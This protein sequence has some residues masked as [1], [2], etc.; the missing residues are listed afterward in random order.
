[1][2]EKNNGFRVNIEDIP[3][4]FKQV[5]EPSYYL[6]VTGT[7]VPRHLGK[8][9]LSP[10]FK[11]ISL[12]Y[13]SSGK[14]LEL[15]VS[16]R[17]DTFV[18]AD[19]ESYYYYL[20]LPID[21]LKKTFH[22][23]SVREN[24]CSIYCD[25]ISFN[26]DF[27]IIK[28][29]DKIL[30]T[31]GRQD[32][33]SAPPIPL[34]SE[35]DLKNKLE[36]LA[37]I[38]KTVV[39]GVYTQSQKNNKTGPE[40]DTIFYIRGRISTKED[41]DDYPDVQTDVQKHEA[42][43]RTAIHKI[44]PD[45]IE[46][47]IDDV[48]GVDE[49]KEEIMEMVDIF[50]NPQKY[51]KLGA[52]V[53]KGALLTGPPGAGKTMLALAVAKVV[54]LPI[55]CADGS[56]FVQ[57][58]VGR[59]A[60]RIRE[61]FAE[62]RKN[63]PCV[64][65]IDELDSLAKQRTGGSGGSSEYEHTLGQLL[66][67]LDGFKGKKNKGIIVIGATNVPEL[68]DPGVT[69]PGRLDRQ[70]VLDLPDAEGR[71]AI[72]RVHFRNKPIAENVDLKKIALTTPGFSGA[73]IALMANEAA[74]LAARGEWEE[75]YKTHI[76]LARE[77]VKAGVPRKTRLTDREKIG[78]AHHEAGHAI[79]QTL[80]Y[81]DADPVEFAT[82]IP[83]GN[84]LG[85]VVPF[86]EEDLR[87]LYKNRLEAQLVIF[88]AGRVAEEIHFGKDNYS[89]AAQ[90]DISKAT[91]FVINMIARW[92]MG[93]IGFINL[94]KDARFRYL[95][96]P[97]SRFGDLDESTKKSI[98]DYAVRKLN[99]AYDKAAEILEKHKPELH[100]LAKMLFEQETLS[101]EEVRGYLNKP[102]LTEK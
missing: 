9:A 17:I 64:L 94:S 52:K 95:D 88:A 81:P 25:K 46:E 79:V 61:L 92:G 20:E 22:I 58:Y 91:E 98:Y 36:L 57:I 39:T 8:T 10:P 29:D 83:R 100:G 13:T 12:L 74:L 72:L 50:K 32:I 73:D 75:I 71:E 16:M 85:V 67:E 40:P 4:I 31:A 3:K 102:L 99:E 66:T 14:E 43:L 93:E 84:S 42:E 54:G 70:I 48:Q 56:E 15:T 78:I 7:T 23:S 30:I 90:S 24:V 44:N 97:S 82:I 21:I 27:V 38:I 62:V 2:T 49:A 87:L 33:E 37:G 68:L 26:P 28:R 1:M 59:G 34:I 55:Y 6:K 65:F 18:G 101:G 19:K 89:I 53:P 63:A 41:K 86:P 77:R 60:G 96:G 47:T 51:E 80:L 5:Q 11:E 76:R 45:D 35:S 69:R